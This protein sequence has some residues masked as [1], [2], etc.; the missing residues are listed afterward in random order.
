MVSK[1][2]VLESVE[3]TNKMQPCNRIY[4]KVFWRFNMFRA[5]HRLSSGALN[6]I[7]SLWFWFLMMSGVPL[8]TCWAFNKLWNNKFYYKFASCW[9]FLLIHTAMHGSMNVKPVLEVNAYKTKYMVMS[10]DRNAGW[11][12]NIIIVNSSF[13][14][15][16]DFKYLGTTLT[17]Q[18]CHE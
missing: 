5:A 17:Y 4:S 18:N 6:C 7:S 3:I 8:E 2:R 1:E 13:E 14:R 12:H 10:G 11:S 16:E 9:L 15:V